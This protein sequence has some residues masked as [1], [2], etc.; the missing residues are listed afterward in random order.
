MKIDQQIRY[1]A[2]MLDEA[3]GTAF[4]E[5]LYHATSADNADRIRKE[6]VKPGKE[7][8][9]KDLSAKNVTYWANSPMLAA[10]YVRMKGTPKDK[11]AVYKVPIEAFDTSKLRGD[12]NYPSPE[13][14]GAFEYEGGIRPE[15]LERIDL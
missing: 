3:T 2:H 4:P 1:W 12:R 7:A 6:G 5:F 9:W 15:D 10:L 13:K 11:I 8:V 14:S